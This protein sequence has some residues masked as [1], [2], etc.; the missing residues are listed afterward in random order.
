MEDRAVSPTA[1][2]LPAIRRDE[3]PA[4]VRRRS[5]RHVLGVDRP[6]M[7]RAR[8]ADRI[9]GPA[10]E[11]DRRTE[12]D[13]PVAFPVDRGI[14]RGLVEMERLDRHSAEKGA[15]L[16]GGVRRANGEESGGKQSANHRE[17]RWVT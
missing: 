10:T 4:L 2:Q 3:Q 15:R 17:I 11:R 6:R 5:E 1:L 8:C 14:A 7:E 12:L 16:R 13:D 9:S